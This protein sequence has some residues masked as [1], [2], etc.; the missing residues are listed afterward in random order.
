MT[1]QTRRVRLATTLGCGT[2]IAILTVG[3]FLRSPPAHIRGLEAKGAKLTTDF[4]R[5]DTPDVLRPLE[6]FVGPFHR[7]DKVIGIE[8]RG[9]QWSDDDL[10][11]VAKCRFLENLVIDGCKFSP[12]G[13]D[14]LLDLEWLMHVEVRN[15]FVIDRDLEWLRSADGLQY[16]RVESSEMVGKFVTDLRC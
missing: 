4:T 16:L 12:Q 2:L 14:S 10:R 11:S 5:F 6:R 13:W 9:T 3:F 1:R 7:F 8:L 15:S